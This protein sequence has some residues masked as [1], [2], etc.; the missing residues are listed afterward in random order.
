MNTVPTDNQYEIAMAKATRQWR[1]GARHTAPT[2]V[3]AKETA[4]AYWSD[5]HRPAPA[6]A[7]HAEPNPTY[8]GSYLLTIRCP[9]C[10]LT[11]THGWSGPGHNGGHR[12]VHCG[13][14]AVQD[15]KG[16]GYTIVIPEDLKIT[17]SRNP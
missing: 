6:V 11:H 9:Y 17:E 4:A 1:R 8:P 15:I 5:K 12:A 3:K 10:R 14:P 2:I 7:L 13:H 16:K